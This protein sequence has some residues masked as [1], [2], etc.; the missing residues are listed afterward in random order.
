MFFFAIFAKF[1]FLPENISGATFF[2]RQILLALFFK[3]IFEEIFA[4]GLAT[5]DQFIKLKEETS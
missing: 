3:S 1:H 5:L 4:H 2:N